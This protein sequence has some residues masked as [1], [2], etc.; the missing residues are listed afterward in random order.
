VP[1]K[2][3]LSDH[4]LSAVILSDRQLKEARLYC[5]TLIEAEILENYRY[6]KYGQDC[7]I[8]IMSAYMC[9]SNFKHGHMQEECK[10]RVKGINNLSKKE[11]K[12]NKQPFK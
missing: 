10:F 5:S 6:Q 11:S 1:W 8:I 2:E 12:G 9:K 3:K 7:T 4:Q